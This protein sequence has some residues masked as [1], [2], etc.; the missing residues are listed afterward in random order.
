MGGSF[1]ITLENRVNY[2]SAYIHDID[3][4]P[5]EQGGDDQHHGQVDGQCSLKE[6]WFEEGCWVGY[7][8]E[9]KGW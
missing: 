5:D 2:A 1:S 7:T 4:L 9:E 3:L 6:E 8:Q